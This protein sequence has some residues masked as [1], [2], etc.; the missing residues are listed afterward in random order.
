DADKLGDEERARWRQQA[1][2]WLRADLALWGKHLK[3][4]TPGAAAIQKQLRRWQDDADLAGLRDVAALAQLPEAE[5]Q[6]CRHLWADVAE[7]LK[8]ARGAE[9]RPEPTNPKAKD[10]PAKKP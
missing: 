4:K 5:R 8:Q 10:V 3:G 6:A 9:K 2:D 7:L 1:H